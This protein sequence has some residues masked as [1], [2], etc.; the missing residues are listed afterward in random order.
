[1]NQLYLSQKGCGVDK[2][3]QE[4]VTENCGIREGWLKADRSFKT[5]GLHTFPPA[6][7][8]SDAICLRKRFDQRLSRKEKGTVRC[9]APTGATFTVADVLAQLVLMLARAGD[10][11][12][13]FK[14]VILRSRDSH[15]KKSPVY[16]PKCFISNSN[17]FLNLTQ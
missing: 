17:L 2:M 12:L 4:K 6:V 15:P 11:V 8:R 10:A 5:L 16:F 7:R 3:R 1:M 13:C 9:A 14:H